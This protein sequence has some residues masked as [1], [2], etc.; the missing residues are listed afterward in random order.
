MRLLKIKA[1]AQKLQKQLEYAN[2]LSQ[3][4][5]KSHEEK[6]KKAELIVNEYNVKLKEV[7]AHKKVLD[8]ENSLKRDA[9]AKERDKIR[10]QKNELKLKEKELELRERSLLN[11]LKVHNLEQQVKV[12]CR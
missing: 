4:A 9:V 12:Q 5:K 6:E 1:N 10:T 7:E 8:E 2:Q 11:Q 3:G